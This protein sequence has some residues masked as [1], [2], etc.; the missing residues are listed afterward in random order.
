MSSAIQEAREELSASLRDAGLIRVSDGWA[1]AS[2]IGESIQVVPAQNGPYLTYV[3]MG[4]G[5]ELHMEV[6]IVAKSYNN[7][8]DAWNWL[9]QHVVTVLQ[10]TLDW[11]VS[12]VDPPALVQ[13]TENLS[14]VIHLSR[15]IKL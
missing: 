12:G 7:A 13:G 10:S 3:A 14:V 1:P 6:M 15:F 8:K 5:Y 4:E 11:D 2:N 9:D